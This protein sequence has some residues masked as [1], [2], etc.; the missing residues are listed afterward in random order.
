MEKVRNRY[1]HFRISNSTLEGYY[2]VLVAEEK[3]LLGTNVR[4]RLAFLIKIRETKNYIH[5]IAIIPL[6]LLELFFIMRQGN[7]VRVYLHS[8]HPS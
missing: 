2:S 3:Q 1:Y 5:I 6:L 4:K 8:I 7:R